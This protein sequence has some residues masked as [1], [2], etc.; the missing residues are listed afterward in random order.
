MDIR[1]RKPNRLKDFDYSTNSAYFITICTNDRKPVLSDIDVGADCVRLFP[2]GKTV[3]NEIQKMAL[4]YDN[5]YICNYVIMPNHIHIIFQID[6]NGRTQF[7]PTVSRI[8]KQFKG[9][10]TKK[11]GQS[12]W[13]KSFYDH[14]IRDES[15]FITKSRYIDDNPS[16]WEHDPMYS[17][18]RQFLTAVFI[19]SSY[20]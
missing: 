20:K 1:Q 14:I 12:I 8:V 11:I 2:I 17:K 19:Y 9:S 18:K 13:Q 5:V 4:L 10:V 3:Q 6:N 16:R 7:A 15:N